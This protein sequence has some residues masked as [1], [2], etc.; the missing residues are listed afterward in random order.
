MDLIDRY[1]AA[2]PDCVLFLEVKRDDPRSWD[3]WKADVDLGDQVFVEGEVAN[4]IVADE[5]E[6]DRAPDR[7]GADDDVLS[8]GTLQ[9]VSTALCSVECSPR[10]VL[11]QERCSLLLPT[12][13]IHA[14][15]GR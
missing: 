14:K 6:R 5:A 3:E 13:S 2:H 15:L 11:G 4:A 12:L 10:G 7:A 8:H 9:S 1:L